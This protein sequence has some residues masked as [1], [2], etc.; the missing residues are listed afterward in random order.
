MRKH[1]ISKSQNQ[2]R[3][4]LHCHSIYSD[5]TMS[6]EELKDAY[7]QNGYSILAITDHEHP[8]NHTALSEPDFLMLTGYEAHIRQ[9]PNFDPNAQEIHINLFA[10]D[11]ENVTLIYDDPTFCERFFKKD[12]EEYRNIPRAGIGKPRAYTAEYLMI[13][14]KVH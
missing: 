10:K 1:F 3:A 11:P 5:G 8:K 7:K 13:Q 2:Y 12:P 9:K 4:N 6:P 14:E